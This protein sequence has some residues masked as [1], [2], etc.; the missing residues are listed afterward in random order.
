MATA[1]PWSVRYDHRLAAVW[2]SAANDVWAAGR[3]MILHWDGSTWTGRNDGMASTGS[4]AWSTSFD[5]LALWGTSAVDVWAVGSDIAHWNGVAWS[6]VPH[7]TSGTGF[8][9][10]FY[11]VWGRGANDVWAVGTAGLILHWD[12]ST[13]TTVPNPANGMLTARFGA[14]WGTSW[15]DVWA[16][17]G[18]DPIRSPY[19][20]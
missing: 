10:A 7:P 20:Q 14:V 1:V 9:D 16:V 3:S 5:V 2:G 17:G 11:G 12:G 18:E 6:I 8:I 19:L 13:W 4:D 15:N